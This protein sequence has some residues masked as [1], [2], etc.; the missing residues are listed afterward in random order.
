M[1]YTSLKN[2][3]PLIYTQ[4]TILVSLSQGQTVVLC[5]YSAHRGLASCPHAACMLHF[6]G[7]PAACLLFCLSRPANRFESQKVQAC[8]STV[9]LHHRK[10]LVLFSLRLFLGDKVSCIS[11]CK[12]IQVNIMDCLVELIKKSNKHAVTFP[13]LTKAKLGQ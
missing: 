2:E 8:S 4:K 1:L 7:H 11:L 6:C 13:H 9:G 10:I 5:T 3:R 12:K